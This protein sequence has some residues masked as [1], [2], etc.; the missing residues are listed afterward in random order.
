LGS[1]LQVRK[2]DGGVGVL[3]NEIVRKFIEAK[4]VI[5]KN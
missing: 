1:P 3:T 2:E 5:G 4:K